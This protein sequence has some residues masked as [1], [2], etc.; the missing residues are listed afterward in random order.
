MR[1]L[2]E[3]EINDVSGGLKLLDDLVSAAAKDLAEFANDVEYLYN[4]AK[5]RIMIAQAIPN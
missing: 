3:I 4:A 1:Q 5:T 2:T